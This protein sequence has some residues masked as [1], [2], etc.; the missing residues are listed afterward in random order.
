VIG[1]CL[2]PRSAAIGW[3]FFALPSIGAGVWL[4]FEHGDPD[5]PIWSGAWWGSA[6]ELPVT[7]GAPPYQNVVLRTAGGHT[8]TLDDTDGSGG[9]TL[10][11]ATGQKLSL[12][13]RGIEIDDGN[14]AKISLTGPQVSVNEGALDVT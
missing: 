2:R 11:T 12:S 5:H 13:E 8:I 14:G 6:A 1:R 3:V 7:G 4:E 9:I 10:E